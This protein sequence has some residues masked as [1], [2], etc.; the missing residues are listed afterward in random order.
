[1]YI[2]DD[3]SVPSENSALIELGSVFGVGSYYS[4]SPPLRVK[5]DTAKFFN[6]KNVA[7]DSELRAPVT[8]N[9][10]E[11]VFLTLWAQDTARATAMNFDFA[12]VIEYTVKFMEPV[13]VGASYVLRQRAIMNASGAVSPLTTKSPPAHDIR[14]GEEDVEMG[15]APVWVGR[16][17]PRKPPM[18]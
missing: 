13:D 17:L 5:M 16:G 10:T 18:G 15:G 8:A 11:P 14:D 3:T 4:E 7:S 9:P 2:S 12:L 1:M 6:R